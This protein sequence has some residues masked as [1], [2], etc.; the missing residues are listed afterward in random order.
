MKTIE[1]YEIIYHGIEY[2]DYFQGCGVAYT[3]F[4]DVATGIGNSEQE[5]IGDAMDQ[6]AQKDWETSSS[7]L[8]NA[9]DEA[10]PTDIIS[11]IIDG[12]SDDD[13]DYDQPWVHVS[14]RVK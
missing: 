9:Y 5:A 12:F 3:E 7:D 2:S 11:P 13:E 14:I 8:Q 4:T 10:D 6:L 1:G